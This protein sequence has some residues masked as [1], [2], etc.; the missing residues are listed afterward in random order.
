MSSLA[1]FILIFLLSACTSGKKNSDQLLTEYC[2][3]GIT[4]G[5]L[6]IPT[7]PKMSE[8]KIKQECSKLSE[9]FVNLQDRMSQ[10]WLTFSL[11]FDSHQNP[12]KLSAQRKQP[13]Q[14][15]Q[16]LTQQGSFAQITIQMDQEAESIIESSF[17][18][19]G[20]SET[21]K[22]KLV[23]QVLFI[24][25]EESQKNALA[26]FNNLITADFNKVKNDIASLSQSLDQLFVRETENIDMRALYHADPRG[27]Y[28]ENVRD[29]AK[30]ALRTQ[31]DRSQLSFLNDEKLSAPKEPPYEFQSPAGE[32]LEKTKKLYEKLRTSNPYHE[33]GIRAREIGL[34]AVET[35]DE[36]YSAGNEL[37]AELAYQIGEGMADIVLGVL[38]VVGLGKDVY[39]AFT[40]RHLL[41]GRSL[42]AF[43]RSMSVMGIALSSLSGGVVS[44]SAIKQSLKTTDKVLSQ[45]NKK[46]LAKNL[47]AM[48]DSR[49][50]KIVKESPAVFFK[51]MED[52]GLRTRQEIKIGL[53]FL[54]RAFSRENPAKGEVERGLRLAGKSGVEDYTKALDDLASSGVKLPVSGEEFLARQMRFARELGKDA[55]PN[56]AELVRVGDTYAL[57]YKNMDEVQPVLVQDEVWRGV[58][59]SGYS[60]RSGRIFSNQQEDLFKFR[61]NASYLSRRYSIP[62]E[63]A[64]YTSLSRKTAI[65]EITA[66]FKGKRITNQQVEDL[67]HIGSKNI[68][69]DK[70]LDLTDPNV[71]KQ[72]SK[73]SDSPLTKKAIATELTNVTPNAYEATHILGHIAKRKGFKAIKAPSAP[74]LTEGGENIIS[75]MELK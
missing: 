61:P 41:T 3:S 26:S 68:E 57:V 47:R 6:E 51:A 75:F 7:L 25:E 49:L 45:I 33:Q 63:E 4:I 32:F 44:S 56:S 67:F 64:I 10:K 38:P 16:Q 21:K 19:N 29:V 66:G 11:P 46:L 1:V 13:T 20:L 48:S 50:A 71:L 59:K 5:E 60:S 62:G 9:Q 70:V 15:K 65:R 37:E 40:G 53:K 22:G 34:S 28:V 35:A 39:E 55:V 69:L 23:Q 12:P 58:R 52:I 27:L 24:L 30:S 18:L 31:Y 54:G 42:T 8:E 17:L 43:E 2:F 36:E 14:E 74:T 73:N 72:L